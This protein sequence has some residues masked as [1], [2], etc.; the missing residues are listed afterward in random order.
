MVLFFTSTLL[1]AGVHA[2]SREVKHVI[3]V[4]FF[5]VGKGGVTAPM[6]LGFTYNLRV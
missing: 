2:A 5:S 1:S 4:L 6:E 3:I